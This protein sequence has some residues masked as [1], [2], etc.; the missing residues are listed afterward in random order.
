MPRPP[1]NSTPTY[2]RPRFRM[3]LVL[4]VVPY[5]L[6]DH[7]PRGSVAHPQGLQPRETFR[8]DGPL[9]ETYCAGLPAGDN[10]GGDR[11]IV[12]FRITARKDARDVVQYIGRAGLVIT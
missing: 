3:R 10:R 2:S 6:P 9:P 7:F 12:L 8:S 11:L 1:I 4:L 5:P